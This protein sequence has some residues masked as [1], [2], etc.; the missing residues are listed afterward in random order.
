[1]KELVSEIFLRNKNEQS[2]FPDK[3]LADEF[4]D[5]LYNLLFVSGAIKYKTEE[6]DRKSVV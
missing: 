4:I 6:E 1:M 3:F 2:N 5:K